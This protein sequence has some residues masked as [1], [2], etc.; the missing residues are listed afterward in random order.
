MVKQCV[1]YN[2]FFHVLV[3]IFFLKLLHDKCQGKS[4]EDDMS[5]KVFK[6]DLLEEESFVL[7]Y[8]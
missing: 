4:T 8:V 1:G 3:T 2:A 7:T 5:F 6:Y